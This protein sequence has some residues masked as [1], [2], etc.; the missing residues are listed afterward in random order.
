[1]SGPYQPGSGLSQGA[2]PHR[3]MPGRSASLATY[4]A[5]TKT[6]A[7][8]QPAGERIPVPSSSQPGSGRGTPGGTNGEGRFGSIGS[9][10][11]EAM[12]G[13]GSG[14]GAPGGTYG[15]IGGS[16]GSF[17]AGSIPGRFS[18]GFGGGTATRANSFSVAELRE[19]VSTQSASRR[20][21][22]ASEG[23]IGVGTWKV[24]G[25]AGQAKQEEC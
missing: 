4:S 9:G 8:S 5:Y 25:S 16:R 6:R 20:E 24:P 17:G 22:Q 18:G 23:V 1:M 19:R 14:T 10:L 12:G 3:P 11:P 15:V 7:T 13:S 21:E 2:Q